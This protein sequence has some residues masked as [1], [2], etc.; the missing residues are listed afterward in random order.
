MISEADLVA[1]DALAAG[2]IP[3]DA[4][5]AGAA[6][7]GSALADRARRAGTIALYTG[8][9]ATAARL[10]H[11]KFS[12]PIPALAPAEIHALLAT[13]AAESP[14]F[15]RVLRSDTCA[16]YL[17]DPAVLRRIGFPGPSAETG[18]YPQF[19]QPP[20]TRLGGA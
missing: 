9:L 3:A 17:A 7:F 2:I 11:E 10:A 16:I 8:G 15:F 18:G 20:A 1:L 13:I 12:R 14:A 6:H 5:D 4:R 19:D